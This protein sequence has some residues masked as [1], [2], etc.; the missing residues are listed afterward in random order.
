MG[1]QSLAPKQNFLN[2]AWQAQSYRN[3]LYLL[4]ALPLGMVYF[5]MLVTGL[6]LGLG[7]LITWIGVPI[8]LV[9]FAAVWRLATF[10]QALTV[11]LLGTQIPKTTSKTTDGETLWRRFQIYLLHTGTWKSLAYLLVKLP[12][13]VLS[14]SVSVTLIIL[15][16]GLVS[17]PFIYAVAPSSVNLHLVS[18][19][20]L[21]WEVDSLGKALL[22]S[23]LGIGVGVISIHLMNG[24]AFLLGQFAR[25]MLAS[26][27]SVPDR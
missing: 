15:A 6:A 10:E 16:A 25:L 12:L 17:V 18:S 26:S 8:L 9:T 4:L 27:A 1:I 24:L 14:F 11:W 22:C 23:I 13:G 3:I 19:P 20:L 7:L 2:T 21:N 5:T